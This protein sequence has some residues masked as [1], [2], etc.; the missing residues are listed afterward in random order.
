MKLADFIKEKQTLSPLME[1]K[2]KIDVKALA[3]EP[4]T[5]TGYDKIINND[6]TYYYALTLAEYPDNFVFGG[7]VLSELCDSISAEYNLETLEQVQEFLASPDGEMKI[8]LVERT[9][10]KTNPDTKRKNTYWAIE[11]A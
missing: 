1:G 2:T 6:G 11:L 8:R 9:A 10:S 4:I 3:D 7:L 5:I